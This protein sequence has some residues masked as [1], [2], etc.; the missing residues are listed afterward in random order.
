MCFF[1]IICT[2]VSNES[3]SIQN[4]VVV[5]A[6]LALGYFTKRMEAPNWSRTYTREQCVFETSSF[7]C[8]EASVLSESAIFSIST[9]NVLNVFI[10]QEL[11]LSYLRL[12]TFKKTVPNI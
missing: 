9:S 3:R 2:K 5:I 11:C 4:A 7:Q 12:Y 10:I 8:A 6:K 1:L